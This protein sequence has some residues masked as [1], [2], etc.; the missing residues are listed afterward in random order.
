MKTSRTN[1]IGVIIPEID[2]AYFSKVV[3][4]IS[5]YL[6]KEHYGMLVVDFGLDPEREIQAVDFLC[7]KQVDGIIDMPSNLTGEHLQRAKKQNLPIVLFDR[8][9]DGQDLIT[10]KSDNFKAIDL[11][12][13]YLFE[14][15]HRNIGFISGNQKIETAREREKAYYKSLDQLGVDKKLRYVGRSDYVTTESA[16]DTVKQLLEKHPNI[17]AVFASNMITMIG[18]LHA[19]NEMN[20]KIPDDLSFVG[21]DDLRFAK[22]YSPQLIEIML[23]LIEGE[24][25]QHKEEIIFDP[26]LIKGDSVKDLSKDSR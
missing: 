24:I 8:S 1:T 25:K 20:I 21:F 12:I 16:A 23:K 11:A 4:S 14:K 9:I 17:S 26:W 2:D 22:A 7:S 18:C 6:H 10:V 19:F 5:N 3:A 15:G 13:Q